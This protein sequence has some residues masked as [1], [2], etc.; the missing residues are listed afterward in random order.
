MYNSVQNK[1]FEKENCNRPHTIYKLVE[2]IKST[3]KILLSSNRPIKCI[4]TRKNNK[5]NLK[6]WQR[7]THI[8]F[9]NIS[10]LFRLH[11]FRSNMFSIQ[12]GVFNIH[13]LSAKIF[14]R[15]YHRTQIT[16][17][18][19]IKTKTRNK[20]VAHTIMCIIYPR[21]SKLNII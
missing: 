2:H 13:L 8:F 7:R 9:T 1:M 3:R 17:P 21:T 19:H 10:L 15:K 6:T 18:V 20:L 12:L 16:P 4:I 5:A 11:S 14:N